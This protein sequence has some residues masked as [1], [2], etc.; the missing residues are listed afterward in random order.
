MRY[1]SPKRAAG[2]SLVEVL[3]A[4][5]IAG[6]MLG[7]TA[8]V[9]RNG[10]LGHENASDVAAAIALADE[11]IETAGVTETLRPGDST[12]EFGRFRWRLSIAPYADTEAPP[13]NLRLFRIAIEVK[14]RDGLRQRQ[15]GLTT[16]RLAQVPP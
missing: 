14:W 12:G 5:A 15:F 16:L 13:P 1:C 10:L 7:A 3:F 9:F 4:L 2:F 6:L 8:G 11:K